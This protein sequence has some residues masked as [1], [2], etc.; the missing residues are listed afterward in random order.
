MLKKI[1][2]YSLSEVI[3]AMG[4]IMILMATA[5]PLYQFI[6]REQYLLKHQHLIK[7][8]LHDELQQVLWGKQSLENKQITAVNKHATIT[9]N[10]EQE[11][12]KGCAA[13]E[14]VKSEK[15]KV[16]LYGIKER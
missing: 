2:G 1:N 14:N 15:E 5:L 4:I 13:W 10:V 9:F 3:V 6:E 7:L 12:I 16:C 8:K 11:Y